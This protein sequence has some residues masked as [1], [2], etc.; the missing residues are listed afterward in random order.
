MSSANVGQVGGGGF[1]NPS[2]GAGT[3]GSNKQGYAHIIFYVRLLKYSEV[4]L[5]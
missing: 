4:K 5:N 3:F 2:G 1:V